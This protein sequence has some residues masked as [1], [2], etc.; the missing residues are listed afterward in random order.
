M[1]DAKPI[2]VKVLKWLLIVKLFFLVAI[3]FAFAAV[4]KE[5][6]TN[7]T[8]ASNLKRF[9]IKLMHSH[10]QEPDQQFWNLIGYLGFPLFLTGAL[11]AFIDT[12][13]FWIVLI[14]SIID[15]PFSFVVYMG[16][17]T[18]A[19]LVIILTNPTR[20]YLRHKQVKNDETPRT[21]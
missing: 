19:T 7:D 15:L 4:M 6:V 20:N 14:L 10:R 21:P 18:I 2:G 9:I 11:I 17:F 1:D 16:L 13:Q 3:I 5:D 12:R 8:F